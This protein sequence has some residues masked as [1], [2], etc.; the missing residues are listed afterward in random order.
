MLLSLIF[1]SVWQ[2]NND[3]CLVVLGNGD[4]SLL[5]TLAAR[6]K[7]FTALAR[8]RRWRGPP[9]VAGGRIRLQAG[10]DA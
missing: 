3:S 4:G 9:A 6:V 8:R 5:A 1:L 2:T 10:L 7:A